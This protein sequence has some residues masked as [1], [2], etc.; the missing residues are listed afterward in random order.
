MASVD[1]YLIKIRDGEDYRG[2]GILIKRLVHPATVGSDQLTVSIAYHN[3]GEEVAEHKHV[4]EEAYFVLQG[5]GMMTVGDTPKFHVTEN[6]C[7][8]TPS[9]VNHWTKN[10]GDEPLVILCAITPP[11]SARDVD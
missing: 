1:D 10:T 7:I 9:N 2:R 11:P 8:Y 3:P 5:E 6:D 4:Y